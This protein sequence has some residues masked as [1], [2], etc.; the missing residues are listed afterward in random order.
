MQLLHGQAG[1]VHDARQADVHA[2]A[3]VVDEPLVRLQHGQR[4]RQAGPVR[5]PFDQPYLVAD[6]RVDAH[7]HAVDGIAD[8]LPLL[9][10]VGHDLLRRVGRRRGPQVRRQVDQRPVVLMPDGGDDRRLASRRGAHHRLVRESD[11][12]LERAAASRHDDHVDVRVGV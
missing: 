10:H 1:V 6:A 9:V 2:A 7:A 11:E 3:R 4:L 12:V 8:Q 5:V